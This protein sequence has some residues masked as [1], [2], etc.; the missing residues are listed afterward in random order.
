[1]S[2]TIPNS[3]LLIVRRLKSLS[4]MGDDMFAFTN[5]DKIFGFNFFDLTLHAFHE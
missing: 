1:M 2:N 5:K 3:H 4:I